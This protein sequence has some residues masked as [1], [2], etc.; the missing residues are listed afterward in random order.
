[1]FMLQF[2]TTVV[3]TEILQVVTTHLKWLIKI[4]TGDKTFAIYKM[5]LFVRWQHKTN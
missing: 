2:I 4:Y 1:M 5:H 3:G